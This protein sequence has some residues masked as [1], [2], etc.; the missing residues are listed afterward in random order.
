[1]SDKRGLLLII[2]A[3]ALW[4]T[5]GT[6]QALGPA[7]S[8]PVAVGLVRLMIAAPAL[9]GVA[10]V[11]RAFP[12]GRNAGWPPILVAGLGMAAYQPVFFTAVEQAGV[13][14]G[15]VVAIGS[16]PILSGLLGWLV[17][18]ETPR[19]RWWVA[20]AIGVTG[21]ALIVLTGDAA[22]TDLSGLGFALAAGFAFAVYIVAS[23][24][25]VGLSHPVGGMALVFS[26]AAVAS[27]PLLAF[28]DLS[29]LLAGTGVL[30]G[31]HLGLIATAFAYV[32]FALGLRTTPTG[33][34]ATASLSEPLTAALLGV[35]LLGETPGIPGWVGV[36][37]I[38][39]GLAVLASGRAVAAEA[40]GPA[41]VRKGWR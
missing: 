18:R 13:A 20:T 6:A 27:L 8:D 22:G 21:V 4:G 2:A 39:I 10:G 28:V 26:V 40:P 41:L 17:D 24:R 34:A 16:A 7:D 29:W 1:M 5:T 3:A 14:L 30:M 25:V 35:V 12:E 36:A 31:L 15:T 32:L 37:L 38:L 11:W 23:R 19:R 33:S 9:L